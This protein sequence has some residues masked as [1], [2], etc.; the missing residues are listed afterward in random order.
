MDEW[1]KRQEGDRGR[2]R[3]RG[4][5]RDRK[6]FRKGDSMYTEVNNIKNDVLRKI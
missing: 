5:K 6:T 2:G 1:K 3:K 4:T